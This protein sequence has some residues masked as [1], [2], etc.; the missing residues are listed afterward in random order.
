MPKF[1]CDILS[2][3]ETLCV[4]VE[5]VFDD[6]LA[7]LASPTVYWGEKKTEGCDEKAGK[8]V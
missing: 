3:F 8:V 7:V 2:N 5:H 4:Y 6:L 1:K